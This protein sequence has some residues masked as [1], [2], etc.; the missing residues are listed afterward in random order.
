[1]ADASRVGVAGVGAEMSQRDREVIDR[2]AENIARLLRKI[3]NSSSR[4]LEW[5][6]TKDLEQKV[7][8]PSNNS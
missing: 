2:S 6:Y 3:D 4:F 1:M 5:L 8:T 7:G